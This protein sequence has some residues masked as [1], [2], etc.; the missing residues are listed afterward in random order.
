MITTF[1]RSTPFA[2]PEFRPPSEA[3]R[4]LTRI[5]LLTRDAARALG[6]DAEAA[7]QAALDGGLVLDGEVVLVSP[8][9]L[10]AD[11]ANSLVI[12]VGLGRRLG[13]MPVSA[14]SSVLAQAPGLLAVHRMTIGCDPDG[15]LML[16]G[17]ADAG[18]ATSTSLARDLLAVRQLA[19]L[20]QDFTATRTQ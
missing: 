3:G 6:M 16:H 12:S 10:G 4:L 2:E 17:I 18:T 13:Q 20:L 5:H 7:E 1:E 11:D 8:V 19:V 9:A 15:E 14:L